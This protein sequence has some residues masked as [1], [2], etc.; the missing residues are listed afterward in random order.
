MI[1]DRK[2]LT[3]VCA[4]AVFAWF[5]SDPR[6][7]AAS[8]APDDWRLYRAAVAAADGALRLHETSAARQWLAEAPAS[9]RGWEWSY[10]QAMADQS[11]LE[12]QAHDA[13][14]TGLAVSADSRW[15]A[16]TSGDKSVRLWNAATGEPR[17]HA[18]GAFGR[19]L[20]A[21]VSPAQ[22]DNWR[23]W[24]PDGTV[25]VWDLEQQT[26][27]H[28][29]DKVGNGMGAVA[30]SPDGTLLAAGTWTVEQ[31][32]GVVG[33]LHLW[34]MDRRE[35]MWKRGVR[36]QAP[37]RRWRFAAT[38]FN[39]RPEPGTGG[40]A[41]FRRPATESPPPRCRFPVVQGVYPAMQSVAY[42][43]D[44]TTLVAALE[45]RQGAALQHRGRDAG[46]GTCRAFPAGE[47]RRVRSRRR[48]GGHRVERRDD[49]ALGR[50]EP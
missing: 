41:C 29:F 4:L 33:W 18:G 32:R 31:G 46:V 39:S 11:L 21:R 15:L 28:R 3:W 36:R 14:I 6:G 47:R 38:V 7:H 27:A 42:S 9:H 8:E 37:S 24:G 5:G 45:R 34:N 44:G 1:V 10:L 12:R 40:S 25:R 30:W 2:R 48:L 26:E 22:R 16:T 50:G 19:E 35:L 49:P 20:V 23:P 17:R 43:P 13:P